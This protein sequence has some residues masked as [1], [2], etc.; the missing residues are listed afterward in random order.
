MLSRLYLIPV[1]AVC[2]ALCPFGVLSR[3]APKP[4]AWVVGGAVFAIVVAVLAISEM[5]LRRTGV[6]EV[7]VSGTTLTLVHA[8]GHTSAH[9]LADVHRVTVMRDDI[10]TPYVSLTLD[11]GGRSV[12]TRGGV[13]TLP[14][15]LIEALR[16]RG[17]AVDVHDTRHS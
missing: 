14:I 10:A 6:D 12:R 3:L 8:D 7:R 9:A 15:R 17:V 16:A 1:I 2:V 13:D 5:R 4:T 11:I